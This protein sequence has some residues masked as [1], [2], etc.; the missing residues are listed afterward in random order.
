VNANNYTV[1]DLDD[2]GSSGGAFSPIMSTGGANLPVFSSTA[3]SGKKALA[4]SRIFPT[5]GMSYGFFQSYG[6]GASL[7]GQRSYFKTAGLW[8]AKSTTNIT[9]LNLV[10]SSANGMATGTRI[11]LMRSYAPVRL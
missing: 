9:K 1:S 11:I 5:I 7:Q 10:C 2:T 3:F 8:R 4:Y 6:D